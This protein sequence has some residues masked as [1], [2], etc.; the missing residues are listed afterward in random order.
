MLRKFMSQVI[1]SSNIDGS[2]AFG[3]TKVQKALGMAFG[4]RSHAIN[5][6][7]PLGKDAILVIESDISI[8]H[9]VY[10]L[11]ILQAKRE[12]AKLIVADSRQT[13]LTRHSTSH[14]EMRAG[15]S[16]AFLNGL[17][18]IIMDRGLF[19]RQTLAATEGFDAF[20][21]SLADYP[22]EK[23][24]KITGIPEA[25]IIASAEELANAK[26][27]L[28]TLTVNLSENTK[29]TDAVLAAA[30]LVLLLGDTPETLQI[31]AEYANT[32]GMVRMGV[33]AGSGTKGISKMLYDQGSVRG[34]IIM[35]EDPVSAYPFSSK[36]QSVLKSLD[37]LIVQDIALTETAKLAHIV[38]P[39][40]G[41]AEKD[42]TFVNAEGVAQKLQRIVET[43]GQSLPDWQILRNLS[44]AMGKEIGTRSVDG[45]SEEIRN[46]VR[47]ADRTP[48]RNVFHAVDYT[49]G[50]TPS[51]EYPFS[52]VIRDVLQHSGTMSTRSKSLDLVVSEAYLEINDEDA[53]KLAVKDNSHVKV[54]SRRGTIYLKAKVTTAVPE[55]SVFTSTHFP[56]GHVNSLLYYPENGTSSPCAVKVE[57]AKA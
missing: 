31:P 52:L 36:I 16:V 28:I 46:T 11:N 55:G 42:G 57:P 35:G 45:L 6:K 9:P 5:L 10:A 3:Y 13:K 20:E 40:A 1:G 39:A 12:G 29:G 17:M 34:L 21:K 14:L 19:D 49:A 56:H 54:S 32:F 51:A 24:S 30:N 15:T 43:Q 50:E 7:A 25:A 23:V 41:W 2:A 53:T 33:E 4:S 27:R 26:S 8:T 44:L 48:G 47:E 18:K 37:L 22:A 38:L